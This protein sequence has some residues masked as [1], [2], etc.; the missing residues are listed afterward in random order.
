M[1]IEKEVKSYVES[2]DEWELAEHLKLCKHAW[3]FFVELMDD[4]NARELWSSNSTVLD[5]SQRAMWFRVAYWKIIVRM[6]IGK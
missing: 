2:L 6:R 3:H 4:D 5:C 1:N